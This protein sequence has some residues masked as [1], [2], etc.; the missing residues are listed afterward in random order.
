MANRPHRLR[1][2][3]RSNNMVDQVQ[4][5]AKPL[6]TTARVLPTVQPLLGVAYLVALIGLLLSA[7]IG[8][9][10]Y[11]GLPSPGVDHL[12]DPKEWIPPAGPAVWWYPLLWLYV[13]ARALALFIA[14][15]AFVAAVLGLVQM[16]RPEVQNRRALYK[17][18]RFGTIGL[19]VIVLFTLTSYG[20]HVQAWL[21]A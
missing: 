12:G 11:R 13:G 21:R 7:A 15:V 3:L 20:D 14:P 2:R 4:D 6:A 17:R 5:V 9:G 19:A 16:L 8:A 18:I 1:G 10:D